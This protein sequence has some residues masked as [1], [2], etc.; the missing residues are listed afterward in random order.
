MMTIMNSTEHEKA[1][2]KS[3]AYDLKSQTRLDTDT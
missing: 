2:R 1:Y 3:G